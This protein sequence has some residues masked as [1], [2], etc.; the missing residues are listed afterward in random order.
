MPEFTHIATV[1]VVN[2]E[3]LLLLV[4]LSFFEDVQRNDVT[5]HSCLK[6]KSAILVF[7]YQY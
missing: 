2:H 4:E 3:E 5:Q 1:L 6:N 7:A